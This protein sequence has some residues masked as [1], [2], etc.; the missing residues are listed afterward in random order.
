M[1]IHSNFFMSKNH[2]SLIPEI[3]YIYHCYQNDVNLKELDITDRSNSFKE[4]LKFFSNIYTKN[5]DQLLKLAINDSDNFMNI[6]ISEFLIVNSNANVNYKD[7]KNI[8]ILDYATKTR[9]YYFALDLIEKGSEFNHNHLCQILPEITIESFNKISGR[10]RNKPEFV[11]IFSEVNSKGKESI[12]NITSENAYFYFK[13]GKNDDNYFLIS[14][15]LQNFTQTIYTEIKNKNSQEKNIK[16]F[17]KHCIHFSFK[18]NDLEIHSQKNSMRNEALLFKN[19]NTSDIKEKTTTYVYNKKLYQ[20]T[21]D[22]LITT[23]AEIFCLYVVDKKGNLYIANSLPQWIMHSFFLKGKIFDKLYGIGKPVACAGDI[24][25]QDGQII[26]ID[27]NS[28]H[29]E[30]TTLQLILVIQH[31]YKKGIISNNITIKDV[32]KN[33]YALDEVLSKIIEPKSCELFLEN[34]NIKFLSARENDISVD[35]IENSINQTDL[36]YAV[37]NK[38]TDLVKLSLENKAENKAEIN[39]KDIVSG[40]NIL[41]ETIDSYSNLVLA[42]TESMQIVNEDLKSSDLLTTLNYHSD[43]FDGFFEEMLGINMIE[44]IEDSNYNEDEYWG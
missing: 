30:P 18:Y 5:P 21:T 26:Y 43:C 22:E 42:L 7:E 24:K 6:K 41:S 14:Y 39:A 10:I 44:N 20:K 17:L 40:S 34:Q 28:G 16:Y 25:I 13:I 2:L 36:N 8:S 9:E 35:I 37:R 4:I 23:E 12:K 19:N 33:I 32:D 15:V 29:Y 38:N 1:L 11:K 27:N 3:K 31:L